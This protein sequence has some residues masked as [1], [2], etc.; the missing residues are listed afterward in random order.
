MLSVEGQRQ[1]VRMPL[2]EYVTFSLPADCPVS[3]MI[4]VSV[5]GKGG[6]AILE[7]RYRYKMKPTLKLS[8]AGHRRLNNF[9]TEVLNAPV[10]EESAELHFT[11]LRDGWVYI[12]IEGAK[13]PAASLDG[14]P[15]IDASWERAETFR[16]IVVR[17]QTQSM[18]VICSGPHVPK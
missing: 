6:A 15:V 10:G 9:V 7:N 1:D 11:T 13:H 14:K 8:D 18:G 2:A 17:K 12:R 5:L 4:R 16:R 3:G